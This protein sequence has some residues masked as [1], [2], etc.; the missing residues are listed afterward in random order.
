MF[1]IVMICAFIGL[2][3]AASEDAHAEVV[4]RKD[5]VRHDGFDSTLETT[6]HITRDDHGDEHGN[7]YGSF[8]WISPEGEH[9]NIK[10]VANEHGYQPSGY[11]IPEAL[12]RAVAYNIEHAHAP[13]AHHGGHH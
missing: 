6:N 2:A 8:G 7:I 5:D 9:I 12:V 1:K 13:E 3:A 4:L 10:Y 11:P